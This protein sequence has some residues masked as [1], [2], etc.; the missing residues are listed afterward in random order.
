MAEQAPQLLEQR[1]ARLHPPGVA[2]QQPTAH[3]GAAVVDQ[4]AQV[5]AA[6]GLQDGPDLL[7]PIEPAGVCRGVGQVQRQGQVVGL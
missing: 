5:A 3:A 4:D 6:E 2:A 1:I 7:D